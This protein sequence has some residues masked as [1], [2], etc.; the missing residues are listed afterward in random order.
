MA[1]MAIACSESG[2]FE[3]S[4]A[5]AVRTGNFDKALSELQLGIAV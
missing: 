4:C 2:M 1:V 5:A 3:T